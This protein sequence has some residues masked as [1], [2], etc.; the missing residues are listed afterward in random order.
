MTAAGSLLG[1]HPGTPWQDTPHD[2]ISAEIGHGHRSRHDRGL[3]LVAGRSGIVSR[4]VREVGV[5]A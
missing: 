1:E 5:A 4:R 2:V 3:L